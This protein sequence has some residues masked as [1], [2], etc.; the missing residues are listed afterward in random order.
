MIVVFVALSLPLFLNE[1]L[2][3]IS[4]PKLT[5][6]P[7]ISLPFVSSMVFTSSISGSIISTLMA[8]RN[9]Q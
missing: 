3:Q 8:F 5:S 9:T 7:E 4:F 1:I 6:P 2:Y